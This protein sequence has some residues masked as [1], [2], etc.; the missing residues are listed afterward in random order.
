MIRITLCAVAA[1]VVFVA[2][3]D[4]S[5]ETVTAAEE[6]AGQTEVPEEQPP[7]AEEIAESPE[8]FEGNFYVLRPGETVEEL[9]DRHGVTVEG[10]RRAHELD[11]EWFQAM[12]ERL[13][14]FVPDIE[15][16][17]H[18]FEL[19]SVGVSHIVVEGEDILQISDHY[20][21]SVME[22]LVVNA[23]DPD[24][25]TEIEVGRRLFI[26]G[27]VQS[28]EGEVLH[29]PHASQDEFDERAR[30][31]GLGRRNAAA[32]LLRGGMDDRWKEAAAGEEGEEWDGTFAWPVSGGWY[33]RGFGDGAEGYHKAVDVGGNLGW[34][35]R[36]IERGIVAYAGDEIVGYGNIVMI[37]HPQG[38][39]SFYAHNT[40]FFVHPGQMVT[41]GQIISEVGSTG[42]SRGPHVH[43][44]LIHELTNCDPAPLFRPGVRR[45]DGTQMEIPQLTWSGDGPP[46]G[47]RC[48][49][50]PAHHPNSQWVVHEHP[51][52]DASESSGLRRAGG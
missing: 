49:R 2:C 41:R 30:E 33:V 52:R 19:P 11:E 40:A 51:E 48:E 37:I 28:A 47:L 10:V 20:K 44:E 17:A 29:L 46:E 24:D 35:A 9:A 16:W 43:F 3:D 5:A 31:L 25:A 26:P 34:P 22:I 21:T 18:A 8:A 36:A 50:R 32:R 13:R 39:V 45:H 4:E 7:T 23:I 6:A 14:H 38:F 27:V 12:N 42:I 15:R 1:L